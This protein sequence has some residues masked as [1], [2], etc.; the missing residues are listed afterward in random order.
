M[1]AT[2]RL[3]RV[4]H[5]VLVVDDS[6][7]AREVLSTV[8][9]RDGFAVDCAPNGSVALQRIA[10]RRPDVV[11]L[12]LEMPG[13]NGLELLERI[14]STDPLPVV[15]CSGIAQPGAIAAIRALE[16][17]AV[18][19]IPKPSGGIRAILD[20][21]DERVSRV[22]HGAAA[23]RTQR[24]RIR[25][26]AAHPPIQKRSRP[27]VTRSDALVV[28]GASTGGT[29][30]L[31]TILTQ[32]PADA[33]PTV[34]VQHMPGAFTGAFA[35]RLNSLCAVDVREARDGDL[36]A[37]GLV[38]I[39]PGGRHVELVPCGAGARVRVFD[40]LLVSGHRPSVD[41]LFRSARRTRMRIVAA[42]LT[43]MGADGA[44][45]MQQLRRHGAHT[46]AQNEATCVVFGMPA[47][48]IA[49]GAA[50]DVLPLDDI[51]PAILAAAAS[52]T[53][54]IT[55]PPTIPRLLP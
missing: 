13:M 55:E 14:M 15:V 2:S 40:G 36:V 52:H 3:E 50:T 28:I 48:A 21:E 11:V 19:V 39:A 23:A 49:L 33:P 38:L 41:V 1:M 37:P 8:L 30:A 17:G 47:E 5:R 10:T 43:G 20:S 27:Q 9:R 25:P 4:E 31:R 24:L 34:V 6:A 53:P 42:L 45:G 29:E 54:V 44:E 51:A 32:L 7:V 46:I 26:V 12:D 35:Q 18:E 22:V 16:L